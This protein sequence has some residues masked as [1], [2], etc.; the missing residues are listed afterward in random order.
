MNGFCDNSERKVVK[1]ERLERIILSAAKQSLKSYVPLLN[2]PVSF[3]QFISKLT[4][5]DKYI[6]HCVEGT[7]QSLFTATQPNADL[8]I[9]IGPEG[10]FSP[11]EIEMALDKN[12]TPVSLGDARLRTE[13]AA[14]AACHTVSLVNSKN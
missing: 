5:S 13:T 10:D 14:I 8:V 9:L 11:K 6:A 3:N 12:F 1:S 4:S 2:E 7:K